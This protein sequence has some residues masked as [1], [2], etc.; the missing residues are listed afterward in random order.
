MRLDPLSKPGFQVE[1][2]KVLQHTHTVGWL[3][4]DLVN[5]VGCDMAV[6]KAISTVH[7]IAA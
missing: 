4:L 2:S 5:N 7:L 6:Y 3:I 1:M